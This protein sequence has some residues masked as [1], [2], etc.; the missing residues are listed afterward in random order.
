MQTFNKITPTHTYDWYIKWAATLVLMIGMIT[1]SQNQ[2]VE[3]IFGAKSR[4]STH[5][6]SFTPSPRKSPQ[7]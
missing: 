1:T 4:M 2:M 7:K 3:V 6:E 5:I